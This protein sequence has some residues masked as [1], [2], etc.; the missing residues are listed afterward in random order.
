MEGSKKDG[1]KELSGLSNSVQVVQTPR[2]VTHAER[3]VLEWMRQQRPPFMFVADDLVKGVHMR[4]PYAGKMLQ[5]LTEKHCL[6]KVTYGQY[7]LLDQPLTAFTEKAV[8]VLD[9]V[10][11]AVVGGV[12]G[13][14]VNGWQGSVLL[15]EVGVALFRR[16]E[17]E[18]A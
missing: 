5:R 14:R 9:T 3:T 11:G 1:W 12:G 16:L 18:V 2:G 13:V 6:R 17:H 10:H 8:Q 7:Q 4:K 15:G